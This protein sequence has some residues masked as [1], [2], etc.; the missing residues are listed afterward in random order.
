MPSSRCALMVRWPWLVKS[1]IPMR[2]IGTR[3]QYGN[4][5]PDLTEIKIHGNSFKTDDWTNVTPKIVSLT[6]RNLHLCQ[7]HPLG[8]IKQRIV[9]YMYSTY[10]NSRGNPLFS[11]H[12]H[13]RYCPDTY[14]RLP[15]S[16]YCIH[17]YA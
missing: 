10:S 11:V 5:A 15:Q 8:L 1:N 17:L 13:L 12:Q 9:N 16:S 2:S 4:K 7:K 3:C 14:W 6:E